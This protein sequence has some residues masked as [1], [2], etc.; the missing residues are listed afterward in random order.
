MEAMRVKAEKR[1]QRTKDEAEDQ[2]VEIAKRKSVI[3]GVSVGINSC[4]AHYT[5]ATIRR[6][7]T[8]TR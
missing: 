2:R 4:V 7:S 8:T 5:P 1:A 3:G 6:R